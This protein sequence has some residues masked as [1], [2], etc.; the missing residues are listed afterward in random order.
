MQHQR[1]VFA[2]VVEQGGGGFV[3]QRQVVLHAAGGELVGN[4]LVHLALGRIAFEAFAEVLSE[5]GH[6]VLV[7]GHFPGRQQADFRHLVQGALGV[8]VEGADGLDFVVE[9]IDAIGQGRA[10]GE[11][12]DEAAAHGEF[13]GR[14][15]LVHRVV[16]GPGQA[17][18]QFFPVQPVLF[19]EQKGVGVEVGRRA[20]EL[21]RRGGRRHQHVH[22][23][24]GGEPQ[25]GQ[26]FGHQVRMG[27][28]GVVGQGFPVREQAH[29][30]GG[31]E[32]GDLVAQAGGILGGLGQD[33]AS[34][35]S[36]QAGEQETVG[37]AGGQVQAK[38]LAGGGQVGEKSHG[39]GGVGRASG[40]AQLR[41]RALSQIRAALPGQKA[42]QK[43]PK[44]WNQ[45]LAE[46]PWALPIMPLLQ[47]TN[48]ERPC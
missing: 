30:Q 36:A 7:Q 5:A 13:A 35:A 25:G 31:I 29:R 39:S 48:A 20:Q 23:A 28:E 44:R 15:H 16:A 46:R 47:C 41:S 32:P 42:L 22:L 11:Q 21:G 14:K 18:A 34:L 1:S 8:R 26:A 24:L 43:R 12:V 45:A 9:Q 40:P 37:G 33:Q 6:A 17:A 4:V 38:A 3:E 10:H 2:Q 27:R 19:L